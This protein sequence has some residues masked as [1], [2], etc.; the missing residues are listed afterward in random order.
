MVV[1][2][3]FF[4]PKCEW[5]GMGPDLTHTLGPP[6]RPMEDGQPFLLALDSEASFPSPACLVPRI[7]FSPHQAYPLCLVLMP[8][9]LTCTRCWPF[10]PSFLSSHSALWG[11]VPLLSVSSHFAT[12]SPNRFSSLETL[13]WVQCLP[14]QIPG[15]GWAQDIGKCEMLCKC[16]HPVCWWLYGFVYSGIYGLRSLALICQG[17][18]GRSLG[19]RANVRT[20]PPSAFCLL[21]L[22]VPLGRM[23]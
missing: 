5:A 6:R 15:L 22:E 23:E 17:L 13:L 20:G 7:S 8:E 1:R 18:H 19:W 10:F 3:N 9:L 4:L 12:Q 2:G 14:G 21:P 16:S 11:L